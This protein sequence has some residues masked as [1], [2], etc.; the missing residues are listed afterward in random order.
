M[1]SHFKFQRVS[2]EVRRVELMEPHEQRNH[3]GKSPE[4]ILGGKAHIF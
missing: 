4:L 3:V 1:E 2:F